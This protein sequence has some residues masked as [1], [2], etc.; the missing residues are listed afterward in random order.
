MKYKGLPINDGIVIGRIRERFASGSGE[1]K[2]EKADADFE[3]M[4]FFD[5]LL[6]FESSMKKV[7][8]ESSSKEGSEIISAQ[9]M[10]SRD[11]VLSDDVLELIDSGMFADEALEEACKKYSDMLNASGDETVAARNEDL[12]EV[13]NGIMSLMGGEVTGAQEKVVESDG[14]VIFAD[15]LSAAQIVSCKAENVKAVVMRGGSGASHAAVILRSMG[16]VAVFGVPYTSEDVS[17]NKECIVDG[18]NGIV[19]IDP[20]SEEKA[21]YSGKAVPVIKKPKETKRIVS[22]PVKTKDGTQIGVLCNISSGDV[23]E[24]AAYSDG[25]GLVRTEFL[26]MS[27]GLNYPENEQEEIYAR[28][29]DSFAGKDVVIRTMDVGGDK[30]PDALLESESHTDNP[31][32]GLRG[33]RRSLLDPDSFMIQARAILKASKG[34]KIDIMIPMVTSLS[35][36]IEARHLIEGCRYELGKHGLSYREDIKLGCMMET[37]AAVMCACEL[38]REVDF[39]SIGTNDLSQYIMCADRGNPAMAGYVSIYQPAVIRAVKQ[40]C[41]AAISVGIPVTVCGEAASDTCMLPVFL[42]LG[43]KNLSVSPYKVEEIKRAVRGLTMSSCRSLTS[44]VLEADT[45]EKIKEILK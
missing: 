43:V 40:I 27:G 4:R 34:R 5:A 33:I 26:F 22:E 41:D 30:G 19:I 39:F 11:P 1:A 32:L 23:P 28:I 24:E 29:A 31:A 8:S 36:V 37:P 6:E 14:D 25:A 9:I 44:L 12:E 38:A 20:T 13:K 16:I 18:R 15:R 17:D 42:G 7:A 21:M 45:V 3:R 10:I 2:R 35:E